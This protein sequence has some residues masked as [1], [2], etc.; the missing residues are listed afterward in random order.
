MSFFTNAY[1]L[2][3]MNRNKDMLYMKDGLFGSTFFINFSGFEII[4]VVV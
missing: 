3:F 2:W 4:V 1:A